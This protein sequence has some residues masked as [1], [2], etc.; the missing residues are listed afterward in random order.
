MVTCPCVLSWRDWKVV[1]AKPF[2]KTSVWSLRSSMSSMDKSKTLSNTAVSFSMPSFFR[3]ASSS[4]SI[5]TRSSGVLPMSDRA[6]PRV[7]ESMVLWRH[8]SCLFLKPYWPRS[9]SSSCR[10]SL[11]QRKRGVSYFLRCFLGSPIVIYLLFSSRLLL[12]LERLFLDAE[13][14]SCSSRGLGVLTAHFQT[15]GVAV[16]APGPDFFRLV[17]VRFCPQHEVCAYEVCVF[18][19]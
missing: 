7:S 15:V 10:I 14:F 3:R 8:S 11:R 6:M 2:R 12:L 16:S 4:F 19:C 18:S 13:G 5:F 1:L 9:L 17:D